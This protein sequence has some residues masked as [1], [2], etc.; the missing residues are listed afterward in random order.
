MRKKTYRAALL[1]ILAV[2][3]AF[4]A[5][6]E[7]IFR[8]TSS[9][10]E[11]AVGDVFPL[12][13][14]LEGYD[15]ETEY[16]FSS[17]FENVAVISDGEL[18][19]LEGGI[20]TVRATSPDGRTAALIV[21]ASS[22][23]PVRRALIVSE[24]NYE[25]GRVRTGAL[26][27]ALGLEDALTHLRYRGGTPFGVTV[28]TDCDDISGA[29]AEAFA[30]TADDDVS[31][32]YISCHGETRDGQAVMV[33]HDGTS[34]TA[35]ELEGM[36]RDI[37]GRVIVLID[38]CS[39]GAFI[40]RAA[41]EEYSYLAVSAFTP[42]ALT[43]GRYCVLCS[44]GAEEESYRMSDTGSVNEES[45]STVFARSFCEGL[46]WDLTRDA[47]VSLRADT[48]RDGI[49]SFTEIQAYTARRVRYHLAGTGARQTVVSYPE[50]DE[51]PLFAR[52]SG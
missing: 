17:S 14:I 19:I 29:I 42:S 40:E 4:P 39:S 20:T 49:V 48:D 31:L 16:D 7:T 21:R 11:C 37:R 33:M 5:F 6:G 12:S 2:I 27:T 44:C 52:Q 32:F 9:S 1:A 43:G 30:D 23:S 3:F 22:P 28:S 25:D 10:L 51:Y 8:F 46:G 18:T 36:L 47:S 26:N 45:M 38:C 13:D 35:K 34:F 24:Q 41:Q 15:E 50:I